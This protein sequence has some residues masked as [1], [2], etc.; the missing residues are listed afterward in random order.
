MSKNS[1]AVKRYK[2]K[3]RANLRSSFGNK[4]SICDTKENLEFA[5]KKPDD[6]NGQGRGSLRRFLYIRSHPH[7]F[8]LLC[9]ACHTEFDRK[10][11]MET[12]G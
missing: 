8:I 3:L 4:C 10:G 1:E 2:N 11:G 9:H 7:K 6:M 5:H 12:Y